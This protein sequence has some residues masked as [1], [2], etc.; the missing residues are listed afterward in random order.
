MSLYIDPSKVTFVGAEEEEVYKGP[1]DCP[2]C[3]IRCKSLAAFDLHFRRHTGE[4]PYSCVHCG[5]RFS[6]K[7]NLDVHIQTKHR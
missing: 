4:K 2:L 6:R 7:Y 1:R 5:N 3:G